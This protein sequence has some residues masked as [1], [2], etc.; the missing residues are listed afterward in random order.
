MKEKNPD[1]QL[2]IISPRPRRP[3]KD[4]H[5]LSRSNAQTCVCS[6]FSSQ[7]PLVL[8]SAAAL[9]FDHSSRL[10]HT[11]QSAGRGR[12][13]AALVVIFKKKKRQSFEV[14]AH[15]KLCLT[16]EW[17][18]TLGVRSLRGANLTPHNSTLSLLQPLLLL[19]REEEEAGEEEESRSSWTLI[20]IWP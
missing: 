7:T 18:E 11:S 12:C 3:L 10:F 8:S 15:S 2:L 13:S 5:R 9:S 17:S 1:C 14:P 6:L 19:L 16:S 20:I 4:S